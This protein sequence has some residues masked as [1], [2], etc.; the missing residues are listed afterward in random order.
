MM[1]GQGRIIMEALTGISLR[2]R[3]LA[4]VLI[5][6]VVVGAGGGITFFRVRS[7]IRQGYRIIG[8]P[9]ASLSA[10]A[11]DIPL[12]KAQAE[13]LNRF[14]LIFCLVS[15]AVIAVSAF[16]ITGGIMKQMGGVTKDLSLSSSEM[17]AA[18]SQ[19]SKASLAIAEGATLQNSS[20]QETSSSLE[21]ILAIAAQNTDNAANMEKFVESTK[22][23]MDTASA[24]M[25]SMALAIGDIV[26]S[27]QQIGRII[28]TIDEIAFQTNL[29]ALNAAVEA[30]RAGEAGAGF[31][32]V[33]DEVRN[34]AL[35]SADSAMSTQGLIGQILGKIKTGES[36]VESTRKS[37][38]QAVE[39]TNRVVH[40][41]REITVSSDQQSKG[42]ENI[43]T[44]IFQL[45]DVIHKS[46]ATSE[47][48]AAAAEELN[49]QASG[50]LDIV[51][52]LNRAVFGK[53]GE[54]T[55]G[56]LAAPE[57]RA[58][59]AGGNIFKLKGRV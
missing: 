33:A 32:V 44:A 47:Q 12:F 21:E 59:T 37:F 55:G 22:A 52:D 10:D 40:A 51:R 28:K 7:L 58:V 16:L 20:I 54:R 46:A 50:L 39:A 45:D 31:A 13:S 25:E 3:M 14:L 57:A 41:V 11:A 53:K 23:L 15:A 26:V 38:T 24:N 34:L 19:L 5:M 48:T 30:A 29:L 9:S 4:L 8:G 6:L 36:I 2:F 18:S 27:S 43:Q 35:R 49:A 42:I 1:R 56:A 17:G